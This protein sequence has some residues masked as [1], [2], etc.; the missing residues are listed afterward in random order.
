MQ[1]DA[2]ENQAESVGYPRY[3]A[4]KRY[5]FSLGVLCLAVGVRA[6][7]DPWLG[8]AL[9]HPTVFAA[10]LV[11]TWYWGVGPAVLIAVLGYPA[12][13]YFVRDTALSGVQLS[14]VAPSL[15]LY[16]ALVV[17]IIYF[18][19]SFRR[20]EQRNRASFD[21]AA[22]G[23]METDSED[24]VTSLNERIC[25]MLGYRREQLLGMSVHDITAPEDRSRSEQLNA[26]LRAGELDR[27][28]YEK[29]YLRQDGSPVWAHVTVSAIRDASGRH[30]HS[31]GTVEDIQA[32]KQVEK[33]VSL[34][35]QAIESAANS[36]VLTDRKGNITWVNAAF[37]QLTG[38]GRD[39][40]I[41]KNPKIL[42]SGQQ[43]PELYRT[44][45]DTILKGDVWQGELVNRRKDG[46]FYTEEMT[47]APVRAEGGEITH[48]VAIKENITERKQFEATL[49]AARLS[50]ERAKTAAEEA[51]Q[52]KDRFLAVLSHELRTPL[53]PVLAWVQLMQRRPNLP[54]ELRKPLEMVRR[55]IQLE[56]RLIDDML[57][58]T[59]IVQG[60]V[61]LER[62]P[63]NISTVLERAVEICQ[64]DI[65]S[66]KLHFS[67]LKDAPH[68]VTGDV[69]RLQ[70]VVWNL[71]NNAI[72]FT[73]DGGCV[74]I[75]CRGQ[76]G[77]VIIE[78]IDSGIGIEPVAQARIFNAFEQGSW[79]ITRQFGGL[80]LGLAIAKRLVE[81]HDGTLCVQ[82]EGKN[83][84]ATFRVSLP[85]SSLQ[86]DAETH[87]PASMAARLSKRILLVEDHGD[88]A[89]SI[90]M[91]L[92]ASGYEVEHA[93]DAAQALRALDSTGFDL[94][95]SD[96][97][98]PDKS[99]L[100]LMTGLRQRG[101]D[102]KSIAL[103]G[104]GREDD[105]RR[106]QEAGF[107]RHLTKPVDADALMET[108][109]KMLV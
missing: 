70:Q 85:L 87:I 1:S 28:D 109:S 105:V 71:L 108:V 54:E 95:I 63:V 16:A 99:G 30:L 75:R 89:T 86:P 7:L 13:E 73:P 50:A 90:K 58:L 17:F 5:L 72:K 31:V 38:Y 14:Y 64:P 37:I 11:V 104:Y 84:G 29:R 59:R 23:I 52:A 83:T 32:R 39:E 24:R 60:K 43:P 53:T 101:N 46:S 9:S 68:T 80:G 67:V 103:S 22:L 36:I 42:K 106:S 51:N 44:L 81:M 97:G 47:I 34:L 93:G 19:K 55:N 45:W 3:G 33:Q 21:N 26:R 78:V 6:A 65:S 48:F 10:V 92:E 62:K 49:R 98:L 18:V 69:S 100:D 40:V 41:G 4:V 12:I 91:L 20:A 74:G 66:R 79:G 96:L 82:S 56:A 2:P 88:T 94:L 61:A 57:D 8:D 76:N 107:F 35:S 77:H 15:G 25:Q 27:L 102:I